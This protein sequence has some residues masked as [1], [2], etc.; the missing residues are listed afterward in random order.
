MR[1]ITVAAA[2]GLAVFCGG[3]FKNVFAQ[4]NNSWTVPIRVKIGATDSFNL[5]LG[6]R[7][8]A[9][10]GFDFGVDTVA[11]PP[12]PGTPYAYL[13]LATFPNFLQ[14]DYRGPSNATFWSLRLVTTGGATSTVSWSVSQVPSAI[15]AFFIVSSRD[16]VNMLRTNTK[17]YVGDQSLKISFP[18]PVSVSSRPNSAAPELFDLRSYPNPFVATTMLEISLPAAQPVAVRIFNLAGQEIRAFAQNR[19]ATGLVKI[20][21]DGRDATGTLVPN[22]VYFCR[23]EAPGALIWRKLSRVQ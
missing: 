5:F 11:A 6:V 14:A 17:T 13:A 8:N 12:P 9:T 19:P 7:P 22:G 1:K 20:H 4:T 3:Q 2:L 16:T 21:W 15:P 23:L 18:T 10:A